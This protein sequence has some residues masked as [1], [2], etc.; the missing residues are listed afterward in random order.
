MVPTS[1]E[2]IA[3]ISEEARIDA[4]KLQRSSTLASLN[5]A[6]LDIMSVLFAVEEKYGVEI[7]P[8]ELASSETLGQ[9]V[10]VIR[11]KVEAA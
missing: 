6:S 7:A 11:A 4:A 9:L 8:E 5:I 10:D 3:I 1:E 2:L